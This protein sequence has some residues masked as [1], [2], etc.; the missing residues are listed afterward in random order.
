[1]AQKEGTTQPTYPPADTGKPRRTTSW[2]RSLL[3]SSQ[4]IVLV[5][6]AAVF[7][8]GDGIVM[9]IYWSRLPVSAI[10]WL[11]TLAAYGAFGGVYRIWRAHEEIHEQYLIGLIKDVIPNSPLDLALN[12]ADEAMRHA[13]AMDLI[14]MAPYLWL[15]RYV[16]R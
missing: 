3:R 15:V 14:L 7:V 4:F 2:D 8:V 10:L 1:M 13:L 5:I 16:A 12:A 11:F 9:S 6:L